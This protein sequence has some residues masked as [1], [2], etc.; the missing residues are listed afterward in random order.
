MISKDAE[1]LRELGREVTAFVPDLV[2]L[3][4]R[5]L[6][7]PRVPQ[8]VKIETAAT[9]GYLVSPKNRLTNWI[10][11][12]GQL[13][14]VALVALAFRRLVTGAG[15]PV[16]R[17]HWRGSDRSF[18]MLVDACTALASPRGAIR[19]IMVAKTLAASA[20]E[21]IS[22]RDRAGETMAAGHRVV[23]GEVV[24]RDGGRPAR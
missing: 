4:R 17:E 16:L 8:S 1:A 3:V 21:R 7:D 20:F 19:R 10:P 23:D 9:L 5:V 24:N 15:E 13:D 12:V 6:A 2:H 14:D 22:G 11:V 18:Q